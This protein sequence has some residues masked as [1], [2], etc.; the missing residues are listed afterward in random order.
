VGTSEQ[1]HQ[2]DCERVM[3]LDLK[4]HQ[5]A[6]KEGREFLVRTNPYSRLV[7][8]DE[9]VYVLQDGCVYGQG[10]SMVEPED[11]PEWVWNTIE[12]MDPTVRGELKMRR[13]GGKAHPSTK[14]ES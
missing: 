4:V 9:P 2:D 5:F 6:H 13:P 12:A 10:G 14:K 1:Q 7:K 11:V 8:K 3:V